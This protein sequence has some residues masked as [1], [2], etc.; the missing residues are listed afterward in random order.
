MNKENSKKYWKSLR[1][2]Y[3]PE[4][5]QKIKEDE[6]LEGAVD[7]IDLAGM[8]PLTRRKF[9]ALL[10]ASSAFAVAACSNYRDKGEIV[11]YN[12]KPEEI[13]LGKAN[14]YASTLNCCSSSCSV[15]VKTREGRPI[16]IDGNPDHPI[17]QG[18]VCVRGQAAILNLYDPDRLKS[19]SQKISER[20]FSPV[21]WRDANRKVIDAL[22]KSI[23]ENKEIAIIS[24]GINSPTGLQVLNE[25]INKYPTTKLYTYNNFSD[26]NRRLAW[27]DVYGISDLPTIDLIKAK[28]ILSIESDFLNTN[29]D[30]VPQV[31]EFTKTRDVNDLKNFSRLYVVEG[32]LTLTGANADYR[33]RLRPD[34]Q[35]EFLY[36]LLNEILS[37][38]QVATQLAIDFI[39]K[40][41]N[42]SLPSIVT[43]YNLPEEVI[44][45]LVIDLLN[46][47]GKS[48]VLTGSSSSKNVHVLT[49]ILNE[50]LGA[51]N[52]YNY[53]S[54]YK[55]LVQ[56]KSLIDFEELIKK[57]KDGKVGCVINYDSNPV[58]DFS[59]LNFADGLKKVQNVF[60]LSEQKT[61]TTALSTLVLPIHNDL[62]SWND[63]QVRSNFLNLQQPVIAPMY[64]T[65]QKESILIILTTEEVYY[66]SIYQKKLKNR[67]Q[68]EVYPKMNLD[69]DFD[70]FW[71][72][73]LHNGFIELKNQNQSRPVFSLKSF[74]DS[75]ESKS[76]QILLAI[77]PH[78][79]LY[80]GKFG[81]NGW[82]Y[83]LPHPISKI[84][85]D[86][87]AAIS[88]RTA[89]SYNLENGDL[90]KITNGSK[91]ITVPVFIQAGLADNLLCVETGFGHEECGEIGKDVGFNVSLLLNGNSESLYKSYVQIS[92]TGVKYNLVTAQEHHSLD[93]T[94]VKDLHK[95]RHIIKEGTLKQF[96]NDPDFIKRDKVDLHSIIHEIKYE[97]VKWAIAIDLNK[98]IGCN[99]CIVS[100]IA[101]NNIPMVGKD[102]VEKGREMHWMRVDTYYSGTPEDVIL[103]NQP[104]L[105]QHCDNAPCETVCPV[106]A[107]NHSPD[108]L[109]QMV[110]NRCVGTRYCSNNCP[111]KVRRFN[112]FDFRSEFEN[113]YQYQEPLNFLNN[114][115]VTI[116]SRGVMEKCTFCI[117]RIMEARERAVEEGKEF[118][119]N[120]VV[121]ACQ[122]ACPANAI[123]FGNMLD[124]N[125][126]I[127][128]LRN[129]KLGY[130]VLEETNVKPNV[131]YI[132]KLRNINSEKV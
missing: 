41:R 45:Q 124:K 117:Q 44:N 110:Y 115:E 84:V 35:K 105:C 64:D 120:G 125:S 48:I 86:N 30:F 16:K 99:A 51:S 119:G 66:D 129:H 88:T 94:F 74:E 101:E 126:A 37:R 131:T 92:K 70:S 77:Y 38:K 21:T 61:E 46:N 93:D 13:I 79:H 11:S 98:C 1:E 36:G 111:Y 122:Q 2:F 102:Q 19:P 20:S 28:V 83:E 75:I 67:W 14:F 96:E 71:F 58:Y 18:K 112:F 33:I 69:I 87:Y 82:L 63:F 43:K 85:W 123:I 6:F 22:K 128:K 40:V 108:G 54:T 76:D 42:Y 68:N 50:I 24:R 60:T 90:I 56:E 9:L 59:F 39:S 80:D 15:L 26:L 10:S 4:E 121:T 114:P 62:E 52:L 132:A 109:N 95:E 118:D 107:T 34:F 49:L 106:A 12:K 53:N 3:N 27:K 47:P 55:N 5:L 7:N 32:N 25:F 57:M 103:I 17:N 8:P 116:R 127:Y 65:R 23:A 31:R 78:P 72:S 29:G 130:Y 97:G 81:N 100:C 104:M 91:T 73:S 89:K 113:D